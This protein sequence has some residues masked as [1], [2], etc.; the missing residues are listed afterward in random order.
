MA[1]Y[2]NKRARL[3]SKTGNNEQFTSRSGKPRALHDVGIGHMCGESSA[4]IFRFTIILLTWPAMS[5]SVL[6]FFLWHMKLEVISKCEP[7]QDQTNP[8]ASSLNSWPGFFGSIAMTS[9]PSCHRVR[10][11]VVTLLWSRRQDPIRIHLCGVKIH[12]Q[13]N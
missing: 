10:S 4:V 2:S 9:G 11:I 13:V 7:N 8:S 6:D 12:F 5:S 3:H 1:T